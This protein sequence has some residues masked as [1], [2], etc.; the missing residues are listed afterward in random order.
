[1]TLPLS[2]SL[3]FSQIATELGVASN[4]S[5]R[6]LSAA[7]GFSTPDSV[8][9]FYGYSHSSLATGLVGYYYLSET[10]SDTLVA[11]EVGSVTG[12]AQGTYGTGTGYGLNKGESG[13]YNTSYR[14]NPQATLTLSGRINL[15][16]NGYRFTTDFTVSMWLKIPTA[17]VGTQGTLFSRYYSATG[18]R[19]YMLAINAAGQTA[20]TVWNP[21]NVK[22]QI[23]SAS[24]QFTNNAWHHLVFIKRGTTMKTFNNNVE[25]SVLTG[26]TETLRD[27][28]GSTSSLMT[29]IGCCAKSSYVPDQFLNGWLDEIAVW[30]Y[31]LPDTAV[32]QLYNS[33][34][35]V[36]YP[37]FSTTPLS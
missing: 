8:S 30:D 22:S 4:T 35:G 36:F 24:G 5:M 9:D 23:F 19:C 13:M 25:I 15:G 33:G 3:S 26:A 27:Q 1:M 17:Q 29:Y 6:A 10:T 37:D 2:G 14:F 21:S 12:A 11:T 20:F 31:G 32:S 16:T 34:T 18:N 28:A 7:A